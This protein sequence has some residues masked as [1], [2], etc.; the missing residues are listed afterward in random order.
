MITAIIF[1]SIHT[2][3]E[4]AT[5]VLY[6]ILDNPE[7]IEALRE[8]QDQVFRKEGIDENAGAE[9]FTRSIIKQFVKLDSVCRESSRLKNEF[10][11]LP[12]AYEGTTPLKL[13]N[14]AII[15]PGEEVLIDIWKNHRDPEIQNDL[16]DV[17][18]FKPFRFV[19]SEKQ[20]TKVGEDFLVF[21]MGRHAC[22]G[23]WFAMQEVE[24]IISMII[25]EYD[26]KATTPV[27]Y[28]KSERGMPGGKFRLEKRKL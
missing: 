21:G 23:R 18:Q 7:V 11:K 12:H 17:E 6:R 9:V 8:E 10:I 25:R 20:A 13:S 28:P 3:S 14:G 22:P 19:S 15:K 27:T 5:T 26:I 2:T 1:A 24:T 4:A 16:K